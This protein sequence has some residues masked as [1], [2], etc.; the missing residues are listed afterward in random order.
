MRFLRNKSYHLDGGGNR[1]GVWLAPTALCMFLIVLGI[2]FGAGIYEARIVFPEWLV[3]GADSGYRWDAEA[4]RG[5]DTGL[6]FWIY[7]TTVPLTLLTLLNLWIALRAKGVARRWWLAAV[8]ATIVERAMTFFYFIPTMIRLQ[9]TVTYTA[10]QAVEAA[11]QWGALNN[12]RHVMTLVAWAFALRALW[13]LAASTAA[14][15]VSNDSQG[16]AGSSG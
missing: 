7:V 1:E 15:R 3:A 9:D 2:S 5:H 8:A 6:R 14:R 10:S 11:V 4:A 12:V 16:W 13:L